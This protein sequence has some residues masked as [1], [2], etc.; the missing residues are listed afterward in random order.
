L[1]SQLE[2]HFNTLLRASGIQAVV[3]FRFAELRAAEMLRDAQTEAMRISN[4]EKKY[5]N[6]W[7]TQDE[8]SIEITGKPAAE[9]EPRQSVNPFT[10]LIEGDGDG[11]EPKDEELDNERVLWGM[12]G[13][14][15]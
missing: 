7:I 14:A 2:K 5:K 10:E 6:G 4:A 13:Y 1:E 3:E 11:E 9:E 12:N 8:A 15:R